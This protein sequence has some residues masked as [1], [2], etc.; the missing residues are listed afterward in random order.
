MVGEGTVEAAGGQAVIAGWMDKHR[1]MY[2][3]AT[4][5]PFVLS[6]R[7]GTVDLSSFKRW[8]EQDYVFVRGFVPFVASVLLKASRESDDETDMETI[9]GGMASLYE[10]LSWFRTEAFK[11]GLPLL[12]II[13]RRANQDYC[14]FLRSLEEPEADYT[15]TM[16]A[17]WA[18]ETVYQESFSLCLEDGSK[19]PPE[20]METCQRWGN[21]GFRGYCDSLRRIAER[22][23]EMAQAG[24]Q[25]NAEA[26]FER[27]L[28]LEVSFWDMSSGSSP[29]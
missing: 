24:I 2:R 5:H 4:K 25:K 9:L 12:D 3:R 13:P 26:A 17:L 16:V 20:L 11:W 18:I 8:L 27:V 29:L 10:E 7:G 6:I 1:E 28:E 23:L 21:A 14:R 15:T 22:R 19:T